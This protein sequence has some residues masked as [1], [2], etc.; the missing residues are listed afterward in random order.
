MIF[1][2]FFFII[3]FVTSSLSSQVHRQQ[4]GQLLLEGIPSGSLTPSE[5]LAPYLLVEENFLADWHPTGT[6]LIAI[7]MRNG[8]HQLV[9]LTGDEIKPLTHFEDPIYSAFP[10]PGGDGFLFLKDEDGDENHRVYWF[11]LPTGMSR[12]LT[13]KGVPVQNVVWNANGKQFAYSSPRGNGRDWEIWQTDLDGNEQRLLSEPGNWRV[14]DWSPDHNRVIVRKRVSNVESELAILDLGSRKLTP[15]QPGEPAFFGSALWLAGGEQMVFTHDRHGSFVNVYLFDGEKVQ[16]LAKP[17]GSGG[18]VEEAVLSPDRKTLAYTVNVNGLNHL[19]MRDL[20]SGR[21]SRIDQAPMG[22]LLDL[23]F[24]PDGKF[25]AMTVQTYAVPSDV[26]VFDLDQGN[27]KRWS[28]GE[29]GGLDVSNF[30]QPQPIAFPTFD[31]LADQPRT[32]PAWYFE[33]QGKGPFP[34]L[35]WFHGG[36]EHQFRPIYYGLAQYLAKERGVAVLMPNIRGSTGYGKEFVNLDDGLLREDAV[37]D[38]G[39]LLDWIAIQKN[40]DASRVAV[41]GESYGGYLVLAMLVHYGER[42]RCGVEQVGIS[43]FVTFLENT[44]PY[45]RY[46]RRLEYGDERD[47]QVRAFLEKVSPLFHVD[48][49]E[50]PLLIAQGANDPRVPSSESLQMVEAL[51]QR[52]K[53]VWFL[54]AQDEGHG[55]LK[56]RNQNAFLQITDLF[57]QRYLFP[58][59]KPVSGGL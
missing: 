32:I 50:K 15:F 45:R 25:L 33:P 59:P 5:A 44:K 1:S 53:T 41:Y 43:N 19:V 31:M 8:V 21:Q 37:R 48:K 51:R 2:R 40:L 30:I 14:L 13:R 3:F 12:V 26:F 22:R 46:R 4:E 36:P 24:H 42:L 9:H 52:G 38:G 10:R 55:F 6:G 54:M 29:V 34:V 27:F 20:D 56:R 39:A 47:Q 49:I 17:A 23:R 16:L 18:D 11:D 35:I 28:S 7:M 57:L 58:T